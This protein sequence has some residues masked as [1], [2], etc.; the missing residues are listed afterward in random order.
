MAIDVYEHSNISSFLSSLIDRN[1]AVHGYQSQLARVLGCNRSFITQILG[2]KAK[3]TA[4]HAY[5]LSEFLNLEPDT[6]SYLLDLIHLERAHSKELQQFYD[7]RLRS[8]RESQS[9][10]ISSAN[11]SSEEFNSIYYSAWFYAVIHLIVDIDHYKKPQAISDLLSIPIK[12][13]RKSLKTLENLGL[14]TSKGGVW[15]VTDNAIHLSKKSIYSK[16]N[17]SNWRQQAI[18]KL[19]ASDEE[20]FHFTGIYT[21]SKKDSDKL[22][23]L[24]QGFILKAESIVEPSTSEE[25]IALCI[26]YFRP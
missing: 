20:N 1:K 6:T 24:I 18:S 12:V 14:V 7:E 15:E 11:I 16:I 21:L 26:D 13:V 23:A 4:D 5:K 2:G 25:V 8:Q 10:V 3:L 22:K 9:V 19:Q 17:H